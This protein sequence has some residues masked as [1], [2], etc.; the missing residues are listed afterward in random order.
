[1]NAINNKSIISRNNYLLKIYKTK[2]G[3]NT[4]K[5]HP[6]SIWR[7]HLIQPTHLLNDFSSIPDRRHI[8]RQ[9]RFSYFRHDKRG[10]AIQTKASWEYNITGQTW[11]SA[12]S[13]CE[14]TLA[15]QKRNTDDQTIENKRMNIKEA[16]CLTITKW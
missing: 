1:M 5:L 13:K 16:P 6:W 14:N 11:N 9:N 8:K 15:Q 10:S 7:D 2:F 3:I 4:W 12:R